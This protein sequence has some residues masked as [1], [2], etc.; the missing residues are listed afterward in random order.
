MTLSREWGGGFFGWKN[1][2]MQ[3]QTFYL[4]ACP[5]W[6]DCGSDRCLKGS[7]TRWQCHD[8]TGCQ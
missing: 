7:L 1:T 2:N 5:N 6:V 3:T 8:Q 4:D